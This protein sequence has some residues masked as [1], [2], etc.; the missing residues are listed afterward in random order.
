MSTFRVLLPCTILGPFWASPASDLRGKVLETAVGLV[1]PGDVIHADSQDGHMGPSCPLQCIVYMSQ[2]MHFEGKEPC[3]FP[4][5]STFIMFLHPVSPRV[6]SRV[7]CGFPGWSRTLEVNGI[8][9][10]GSGECKGRRSARFIA[11]TVS[12]G[13]SSRLKE[14]AGRKGRPPEGKKGDPQ[15]NK[16]R[17]QVGSGEGRAQSW[18]PPRCRILSPTLKRIQLGCLSSPPQFE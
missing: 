6:R 15:R 1:I 9:Q 12:N 13:E 11:A 16:H 17:F 7:P 5:P 14:G 3:P 8:S 4:S 10:G 18:A 2:V